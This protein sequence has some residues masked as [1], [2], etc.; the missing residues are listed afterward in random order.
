MFFVKGIDENTAK[1]QFSVDDE[2]RFGA[3]DPHL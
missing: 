2:T 1:I 3:F